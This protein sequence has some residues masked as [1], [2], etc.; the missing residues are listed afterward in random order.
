M[1]EKQL[2]V[3]HGWPPVTDFTHL[4]MSL[5]GLH[6]AVVEAAEKILIFQNWM[7]Q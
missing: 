5:L 7:H 4:K 1:D 6:H 2:E 3:Q